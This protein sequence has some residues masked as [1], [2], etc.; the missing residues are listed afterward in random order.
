MLGHFSFPTGQS[1]NIKSI[2]GRFPFE[3][4]EYHFKCQANSLKS[5]REINVELIGHE[6]LVMPNGDYEQIHFRKFSKLES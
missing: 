6:I 3:G 1:S 4:T 5:G 2:I